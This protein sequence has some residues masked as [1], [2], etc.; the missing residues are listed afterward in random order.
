MNLKQ[1]IGKNLRELRCQFGL[2]QKQVAQTLGVAYQTYQAY[3]IGTN[4]P[5]IENLLSLANMFDVSVDFLLG[6]KEY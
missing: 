1:I 4:Y 2:T 5:T 3:E 6:Q